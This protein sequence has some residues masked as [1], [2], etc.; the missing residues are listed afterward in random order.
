MLNWR[1]TF[2]AL[3]HDRRTILAGHHMTARLEEDRGPAIR[4]NQA[5]VNLLPRRHRFTA[6]QTL[7][8]AHRTALAAAHVAAGLED[9]VTFP[10]RTQKTLVQGT[11]CRR[12]LLQT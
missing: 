3:L 6:D 5:L 1:P 10:F 12:N 2:D 9:R 4:T 8:H 7:L 11:T